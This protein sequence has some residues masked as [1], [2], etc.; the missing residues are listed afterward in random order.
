MKF[1]VSIYP[2]NDLILFNVFS[3]YKIYLKKTVFFQ[4]YYLSTSIKVT[5][6]R[7]I[8]MVAVFEQNDTISFR[9]SF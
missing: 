1:A 2:G 6:V 3:I 7:K 5:R 8:D 9:K 4:I